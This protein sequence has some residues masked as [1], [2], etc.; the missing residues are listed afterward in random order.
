MSDSETQ[1][2]IDSS[3]QTIMAKSRALCL[4]GFDNSDL[5]GAQRLLQANGHRIVRTF[6]AAQSVVAGPHANSSV[7]RTAQERGIELLPWDTFQKNLRRSVNNAAS[8]AD[9]LEVPLASVPPLP[10]VER[11]AKGYRVLDLHLEVSDS[12]QADPRLVPQASRFDLMC[13]D[14]P[15]ADTLRAVCLG[16]AHN[17]PVAL[18]GE[19]SAS[20]TTAVLWL[21]HLLGHSVMRLN[22]NGQTDAGELVGRYVPGGEG[23]GGWSFQ[24]GSLPLALRHGWWL[25]LDE[26][27]LAEPQILERLNSVLEPPPTLVV[28]E[29]DGTVFGPG[30]DVTVAEGFRIF[31]TLNPAEYSGRSILSPAFRDRWSVWH[32][33]EGPAEGDYHAMLRLLAFGQQPVVRCRDEAYQADAV[34]PQMPELQSL[35]DANSVL[36]RLAL[37]H[38]SVSK[39]ANGTDGSPGLGRNRRERYTFTRRILLNALRHT[40]ACLKQNP[41]APALDVL[42]ESLR[43][44]YISRLSAT[45]DRRAVQNLLKVCNLS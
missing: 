40:S 17:M 14:Q 25:L 1:L 6:S 22:L 37:F 16:V 28:T 19:T 43:V 30:G 45:A 11:T 26:M 29:G 13:Y 15:F 23:Q 41:D 44:F 7:A 27:N 39:A 3:T 21:A 2:L 34:V 33:A 36:K 32:H 10:L 4:V 5:P 20:K 12:I 8:P 42:R 9:T 31:A 24:E 18:E 38:T 35:P